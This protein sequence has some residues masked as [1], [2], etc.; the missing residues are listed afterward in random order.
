MTEKLYTYFRSSA[1][2]RVRIALNLKKLNYDSEYIHLVKNGGEQKSDSYK[3]INPM[4]LVPAFKSG[5]HTYTQSLAII[6][7]LEQKQPEPSIYPEDANDKI[8][9]KTLAY[10]I[11]CDIHPINNLSVIQYLKNNLSA[12]EQAVKSWIQHW[13]VRG[14]NAIE[15][16][17]INDDK[18][19]LYCYKNQA[20]IADICL[21]PQVY[22]AL[23]YDVDLS[24]YPA[25]KAIY[26]HCLA[27]PDFIQAAPE[28]QPDSTQ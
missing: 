3:Q 8:W 28:S 17:L 18:S 23:R 27:Q 2:Y 26:E 22:N 16:Q 24:Q 14:F 10:T 5:G 21:I 15:H 12:D 6:D 25:I 9:A 4:G 1:A 19:G 13:I 11:C 20:T 7:Y